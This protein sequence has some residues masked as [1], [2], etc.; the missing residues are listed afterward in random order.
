M[1][2]YRNINDLKTSNDKN[3]K[4]IYKLAKRNITGTEKNNF[5]KN[6]SEKTIYNQ[7]ENLFNPKEILLKEKLN[8]FNKKNFNQ[9]PN[10]LFYNNNSLLDK[11]LSRLENKGK[12][13]FILI[14][15]IKYSKKAINNKINISIFFPK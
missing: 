13:Y 10:N 9:N 7:K 2:N 3:D 5:Q 6:P 1:E 14:C 12:A 15:L 8:E 11:S 4:V